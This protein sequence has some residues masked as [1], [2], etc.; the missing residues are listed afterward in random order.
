MP[1][2]DTWHRTLV[3]FGLAEDEGYEDD[4]YDAPLDSEPVVEDSYR[5]RPNVRRLNSSR[6]KRDDFDKWLNVPYGQSYHRIDRAGLSTAEEKSANPLLGMIQLLTESR[7]SARV[8]AV[9]LDRRLDALQCIEATASTPPQTRAGCQP[10]LRR[11]PIPPPHLIRSRE[12][13]SI[14]T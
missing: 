13:P 6:R 5:D 4:D 11:S 14:T 12:N 9:G 7:G 3:Y 2:R 10:I 8:A 1:I